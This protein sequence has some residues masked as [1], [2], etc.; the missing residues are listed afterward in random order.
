MGDIEASDSN[1]PRQTVLLSVLPS[2]EFATSR[3]GMLLIAE[4]VLSFV[5]FICFA[6]STAAAFVTV[7][8]LE[9][10]GALFLLFAYSMK[11]NE[12]FKGFLWPLM[13][14]LRCVTASIIYFI[15]SI[16]AVSRYVDG[17]SKAAGIFGFIATIAFALDFYLIFNELATFLKD[18]GQT[19]AEPSRQRDDFSDSD[20]D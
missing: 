19:E 9:F 11:F 10:L 4:V 12:R 5:S 14:F 16:M 2:K 18:G 6:A 13:D 15:V 7:P 1:R 8:L 17:S 3:K 20:S